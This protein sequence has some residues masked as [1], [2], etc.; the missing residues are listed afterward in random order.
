MSFGI[1]GQLL[2]S[3]FSV[4]LQLEQQEKRTYVGIA[5]MACAN[6]SLNI[7]FVKVLGMGMFGLGLSTSISSWLFC[8][9]QGSYYLT[10]K[11]AI[12]LS[13]KSLDF[14]FLKDMLRIG[15]P[16]A[17]VQLCQTFRGMAVNI[18][19]LKYAG[20]NAL[21]AYSAVATFGCVYFAAT[22]GIASATRLL[23]SVYYG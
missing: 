20:N 18:I 15:A 9:I 16:G 3:Q 11:A 4:F 23:V 19:I 2:A 10:K 8:I 21:A 14:S 1:T 5:V 12:R 7:I 22:A 6:V 13:F 17:V